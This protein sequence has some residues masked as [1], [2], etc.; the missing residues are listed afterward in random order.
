MKLLTFSLNFL[1]LSMN[2]NLV[3]ISSIGLFLV[4]VHNPLSSHF[5]SVSH[6][7]HEAMQKLKHGGVVLR[8]CKLK[9]LLFL[10]VL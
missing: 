8:R 7:L 9:V 4:D 6:C 10:A 5:F 1:F 2:K 3:S